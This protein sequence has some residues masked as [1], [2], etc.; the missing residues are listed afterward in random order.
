MAWAN[1]DELDAL[2]REL[3]GD[4]LLPTGADVT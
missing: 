2:R 4:T 3:Y 1:V